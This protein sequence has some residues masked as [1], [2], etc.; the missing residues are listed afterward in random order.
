MH[1]VAQASPEQV[2]Q[3]A[4]Q[5]NGQAIGQL[6][7]LYRNYLRLLARLQINRR[8]QGKLDA[9]DVVQE[10]FLKAHRGFEQFR[11]QS[12]AELL[13]W[14]R[15]LLATT[16]TDQAFRYYGRRCRDVRLERRLAVELDRSSVAIN[17]ALVA[18]ENS[19]SEEAAAREQAVLVADALDCLPES[20]REVLVLRHLEGLTFPEVARQMGRSLGS[21]EKLWMRAL[22]RLRVKL[23]G[24]A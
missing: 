3:L 17:R 4:R 9:S 16:L 2:L 15:Q 1:D 5:G 11:G 12:E 14:L 8:L 23:G 21:V 22:R 13:A 6:L 19:P 18:A 10:V 20:Y 7:S 24:S